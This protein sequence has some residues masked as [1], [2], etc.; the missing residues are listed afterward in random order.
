MDN[1]WTQNEGH[2]MKYGISPNGV[3][4]IPAT[5]ESSGRHTLGEGY[6]ELEVIEVSYTSGQEIRKSREVLGSAT[7][8]LMIRC[9]MTA[10]EANGLGRKL[11]GI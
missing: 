6:P 4:C 8:E 7:Q 1:W 9:Q 3:A 10:E 5:M 11:R 2:F